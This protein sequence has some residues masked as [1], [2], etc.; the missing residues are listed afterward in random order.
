MHRFVKFLHLWY[1]MLT[2]CA[3]LKGEVIVD[4]REVY[5][6]MTQGHVVISKWESNIS[7][8][9]QGGQDAAGSKTSDLL[10]PLEVELFTPQP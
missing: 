7:G 9:K 5:W 1:C 10:S 3:G 6:L 2:L 8:K 4:E